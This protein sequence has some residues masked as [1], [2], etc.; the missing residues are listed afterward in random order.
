MYRIYD[1]PSLW[2]HLAPVTPLQKSNEVLPKAS[3][4]LLVHLVSS[5]DGL[6]H[7]TGFKFPTTDAEKC[8]I[9]W[10]ITGTPFEKSLCDAFPQRQAVGRP[11]SPDSPPDILR[12]VTPLATPGSRTHVAAHLAS[13]VVTL[14]VLPG[15]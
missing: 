3:P 4:T 11:L 12:E 5:N 14:S 13:G 2:F 9:A 7:T 10:E 8:L 15:A 6:A 1:S